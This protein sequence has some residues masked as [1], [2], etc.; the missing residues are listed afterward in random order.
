MMELNKEQQTALL[1]LARKTI[2]NTLHVNAPD[3]D[4]ETLS[5]EVFNQNCG[6]FVT[7][8]KNGALRGCIGYITGIKPI[9]QAVQELAL[10]A[11]FHDPR[12][13]PLSAAEYPAIDLEISVLSPIEEVKSID[14][15]ETGRDG[16][17]IS[18]DYN[19]GLLLPQVAEEYGWDK[20]TFL[21][22]TCVKAGL[23]RDA[24]KDP[25]AK[26]EKFTAQVFGEV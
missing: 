2:A 5:E 6:A 14:D 10:S 21:E 13:K 4:A 15:I 18:K 12:F 20:Q 9:A 19:R 24:W 23:H 26:I 7:V 11:A 22:Q 17:I 1:G 3:I 8:H 16:L 25:E